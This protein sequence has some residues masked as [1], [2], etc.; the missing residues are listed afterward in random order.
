MLWRA[1]RP[2]EA[3]GTDCSDHGPFPATADVLGRAEKAETAHVVGAGPS[4]LAAAITLAK[5]GRKVEVLERHRRVGQRFHGDMQGL[6]NWSSPDD[7]LDLIRRLGIGTGFDYRPFNEVTYYDSQL[8]PAVVRTTQPFFYLV[9]RG[10]TKGTLDTALLEQAQNAGV[11]VTFGATARTAAPGAIV[12]T[13]PRSADGVAVG[14][15]FKTSLADQAHAIIHPTLAPG[16]YAYLLIWNGHGTMAT[17]LCREVH[18]ARSVRA[19]TVEAFQR[20]VPGLRLDE[21]RPFGGYGAVFDA[22]RF[23]DG[24]GRSYVGEAAGLQDAEWGFGIMTALR[25][26]VLAARSTLD[27]LDYD[28]IARREFNSRR[29][30]GFANRG[31]FEATPTK[32]RDTVLHGVATRPDLIARLGKHWAPNPVKSLLGRTLAGHYRPLDRPDLACHDS[33]CLALHCTCARSTGTLK[34]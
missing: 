11:E 32:I 22:T 27:G 15:T 3:G 29:A 16:G 18:R 19:A 25:S 34:N 5:A 17:F 6:E 31:L 20:L 2:G 8:R 28:T 30:I 4:G 7:A 10:P 1:A 14:F 26:G 24:P 12:A 21:A 33:S 9:R 23:T 13:G